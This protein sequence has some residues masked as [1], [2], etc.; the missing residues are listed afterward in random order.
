MKTAEA[1]YEHLP[2]IS[3]IEEQS[4][5]SKLV[6]SLSGF[7]KIL[8]ST[9]DLGELLVAL[10]KDNQV[11]GFAHY[12]LIEPKLMV[13]YDLAVAQNKRNRGV[14]SLLMK[15]LLRLAQHRKKR[16]IRLHVPQD[17]IAALALYLK[18]GFRATA[19]LPRY[20][21]GKRDGWVMERRIE[22]Q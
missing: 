19:R 22:R 14:G 11:A 21:P 4:Y 13:I 10:S 2:D 17:N 8:E 6:T 20:Y 1:L 12:S 9:G 5:D 7:T 3:R 18:Q 16:A 15:R